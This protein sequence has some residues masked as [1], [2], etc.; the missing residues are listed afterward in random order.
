[1]YSVLDCSVC[2]RYMYG[3]EYEYD[4]H[5]QPRDH[6]TTRRDWTRLLKAAFD[7]MLN[8]PHGIPGSDTCQS[9]TE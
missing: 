4:A 2:V 1:M 8:T 3:Y 6:I 7:W 9:S 5:C